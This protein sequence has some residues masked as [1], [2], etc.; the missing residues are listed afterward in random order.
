[1]YLSRVKEGNSHTQGSKHIRAET[2]EKKNWTTCPKTMGPTIC[3]VIVC[4]AFVKDRSV[5]RQFVSKIFYK[6]IFE[7][8]PRHV[9]CHVTRTIGSLSD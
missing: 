4:Q 5:L 3:H 9:T 1:M 2:T 7:S 8:Y 6:D